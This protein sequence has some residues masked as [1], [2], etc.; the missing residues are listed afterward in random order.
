MS[1]KPEAYGYISV[2][3][4][5]EAE[6]DRLQNMVTLH[7][8]AEGLS[9][10]ET[11]VD[12]NIPIAQ[13]SGRPALATVLALVNEGEGVYVIVPNLDAMSKASG[14]RRAIALEISQAGGHLQI[15]SGEASNHLP[16]RQPGTSYAVPLLRD[17]AG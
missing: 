16:L 1:T 8:L 3:G 15:A 12:R 7:A 9:L 17:S 2:E 13:V 11:Y 14:V 6:I 5:D 10:E 4:E